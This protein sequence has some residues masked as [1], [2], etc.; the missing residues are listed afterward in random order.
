MYM[1]ANRYCI[2]KNI[3]L[4]ERIIGIHRQDVWPCDFVD[5]LDFGQGVSLDNQCQA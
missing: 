5:P 3:I 1:W 4:P 2:L